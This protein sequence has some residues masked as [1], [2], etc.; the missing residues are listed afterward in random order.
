[1]GA[2]VGG[3]V[4][5]YAYACAVLMNDETVLEAVQLTQCSWRNSDLPW[6]IGT[7]DHG[8]EN[9]S[10]NKHWKEGKERERE[11]ET[12]AGQVECQ[13]YST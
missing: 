3:R 4:Y 10:D 5:A 2:E 13:Q 1:M 6:S 8:I 9:E 7:P 11:I 12:R